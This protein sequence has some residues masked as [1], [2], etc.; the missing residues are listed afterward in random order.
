MNC[1]DIQGFKSCEGVGESLKRKGQILERRV[2]DHFFSYCNVVGPCTGIKNATAI[3]DR[4]QRPAFP[5]G[6]KGSFPQKEDPN[7]DPNIL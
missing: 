4:Q 2:W 3:R 5:E 7:M 1:I 6:Q